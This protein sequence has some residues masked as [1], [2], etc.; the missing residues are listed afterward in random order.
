M[1]SSNLVS[2]IMVF[3][4]NYPL[5][6]NIDVLTNSD[7]VCRLYFFFN[8]IATST[9]IW[10]QVWLI[11]ER[12]LSIKYIGRLLFLKK[13]KS[14]FIIVGFM[15]LVLIFV[16]VIQLWYFVDIK[17]L[18]NQTT[19]QTIIIS[20]KCQCEKNVQF[21]R[22][23]FITIIVKCLL[24]F[25]IMIIFDVLLIMKIIQSKKNVNRAKYKDWLKK[26][27]N[28][29]ISIIFSNAF[30]LLTLTPFS[31]VQIAISLAPFLQISNP[32]V[33]IT[34]NMLFYI[35]GCF[36][37]SYFSF[38]FLVYLAFNKNFRRNFASFI[39]RIKNKA[40]INLSVTFS[41]SRRVTIKDV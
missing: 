27:S 1:F 4:R 23:I 25:T 8:R 32:F 17:T 21:V 20:K 39:F 24:P 3:W 35:S 29:A 37:Y 10:I 33:L 16:N 18:T 30:F 38:L 5:T 19:N 9:S 34:L 7:F 14:V 2:L 15:A 40:N 31:F 26:E 13:R 11:I 28:F 36:Y 41:K 22:E 12:Y 6:F